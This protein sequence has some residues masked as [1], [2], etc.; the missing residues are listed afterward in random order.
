MHRLAKST[1]LA[2]LQCP[3]RLWFQVHEPDT[4]TAPDTEALR[5]M[6]EGIRVGR[7]ARD[8]VP[9]GVLVGSWYQTV[10][11]R[12]S[13]TR[14]AL[15]AGE[16]VLYEAN[17]LADDV[18][19]QADILERQGD[20]FSLIE[21]K[22]S[23]KVKEE[24]IPDVAVQVWT[25]RRAGIPVQRAELMHLNRECRFPDLSN[26][27]V[28]EDVTGLV[29]G[30]LP[31]VPVKVASLLAAVDGPCPDV[32]IGP[33]CE[34][35]RTCPFY[36]RCWAEVPADHV[37]TLHN[38]SARRLAEFLE[39]GWTTIGDLP[40]EAELPGTAARQVRAMRCGA[41]IVE[42]GLADALAALHGPLGF[43]DFETINPAI[44]VWPGCR[45]YDQIPVQ[46]SCHVEE[47]DGTLR[48]FAHVVDGPG[49]PRAE[50]A[51]RLVTACEGARTL[52]TYNVSF[53]R[54]GVRRLAE[55][56]PALA[57]ELADIES[58]LMDLLPAVRNHVYDPKF[59][60]SFSLKDVLP[61]LVSGPGYDDLDIRDGATASL[62]LA[63]LILDGE[64][65]SDIERARLRRQLLAYCERDT[66]AMVELLRELR[67]LAG[68][69]DPQ[70]HL[71]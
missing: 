59:G 30:M 5:R 67:R 48:H 47:P 61:A 19:V 43:L 20:A 34:Q 70:L 64:A 62:M 8:Y 33:H 63:R 37:S 40:D 6:D 46:F 24:H 50:L 15:E 21:V 42:P 13:A 32:A 3:K 58:R 29:E 12:L 26:L 54:A 66:L 52:L 18:L 22:S 69:H 28:R 35:P 31:D 27:F 65:V 25:L 68:P 56:V 4:E 16:R 57:D 11:A 36:H 44:P 39:R 53:E 51:H 71:L 41:R 9:G 38:L 60:G 55:A 2:G 23:T 7:L 17:V 49:D 1:F 14:A 45:P 10:D